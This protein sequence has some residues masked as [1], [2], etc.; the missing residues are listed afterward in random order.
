MPETTKM[1]IG[2]EAIRS[3]AITVQRQDNR[4]IIRRPIL[5]TEILPTSCSL[6]NPRTPQH[7]AP[8]AR[9]QLPLCAILCHPLREI[10]MRCP[11]TNLF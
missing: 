1:M 2:Q 8:P 4:F 7:L 10:Y 11:P 3:M 6:L 9:V 5:S